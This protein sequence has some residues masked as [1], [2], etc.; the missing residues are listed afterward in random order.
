MKTS[1]ALL[2]SIALIA[3]QI[4]PAANDNPPKTNAD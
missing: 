3:P 1:A 4:A 2:L